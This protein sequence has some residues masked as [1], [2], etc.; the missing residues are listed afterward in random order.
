MSSQTV[1]S[2]KRRPWVESINSGRNG[3]T[4][5]LALENVLQAKP[6]D[7]YESRD[8]DLANQKAVMQ[9]WGGWM[10]TFRDSKHKVLVDLSRMS[11]NQAKAATEYLIKKELVGRKLD[12]LATSR[13]QLRDNEVE[14]THMLK[15]GEFHFAC[16]LSLNSGAIS[17]LTL[18]TLKCLTRWEFLIKRSE[19]D[20]L[21]KKSRLQRRTR[22]LEC[23][24]CPA[25]ETRMTILP[26]QA[27]HRTDVSTICTGS[28]TGG[29]FV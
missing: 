11:H 7:Y 23:T 29:V 9:E 2:R 8:M 24:I 4:Y 3:A 10:A 12:M 20:R 21:W 15:T 27:P 6:V 16:L 18:I 22:Q 28:K 14:M 19:G 13:E 1:S 5:F 17:L 25:G 26:C